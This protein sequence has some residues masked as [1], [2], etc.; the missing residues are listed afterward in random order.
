MVITNGVVFND[1][2]IFREKDVEVKNGVIT[3]VGDNLSS[4]DHE[5]V[6]AK[7]GYVVPGL[8][9]IHTHGSMGADFS[10]GTPEAF[11]TISR[12]Q[13]SCGITSFLGT[14]MS[15]PEKQ[16]S[17]VCK[18]ARPFIN[19]I[20]PDQ[21]VIRGIHLEG[22]F[23]SQEKRGAQNAE[24]IIN[25]DFAMFMHWYE[26]SGEGVRQVAVAPEL[27]D[28]LE[29]IKAA[30]PLCTVSLAHSASDYETACRAFSLGASQVTHL[31]NGMSPYNH[32]EPGIVGAA[33]DSNAYVELITD[34]VHI[35]PSVVRAVFKLFGDDRVCLVS[36]SMRACGLSDG[37]YDLGGQLVTVTGRVAT[38]ANSLAGSMTTL[39]DCMRRSVEFGV[40]LEKALKA[41]T[42][43]PAK[44]AGLDDVGSLTVGKRADIL[45]L[46]QELLI[47]HILLGSIQIT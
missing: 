34:G 7:N 37:Q 4:N 1:D 45:L 35:H 9:D 26:S 12:F 44:S 47:E 8:V 38:I 30:A 19:A 28:G 40:P 33:F 16:I 5:I 43:N 27:E 20:H 15:L 11:Q 10:D 6:D 46:N 24:Y 36:D 41:A 2:G 22:P 23:F 14:T 25:P 3:A 31:F 29:F 18:T 42:I 32:R 17:N 21:A 13:L 39:T